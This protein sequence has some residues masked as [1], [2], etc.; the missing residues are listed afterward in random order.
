MKE[1]TKYVGLD[2]HKA[3][4]AVAIAEAGSSEVRYFGEIPNTPEDINKVMRKLSSSEAT[5]SVCYEAGPCGYEV[6]R[7]LSGR[8]IDC[9]VVAPSMIP[10]KPGDRVKT[11]RRDSQMLA[12]L[13]RAGEL[14]S[15]CVYPVLSKRHCGIS[16]VLGPT[17]CSC[18]PSLVS[19]L[20]D[21]VKKV[22]IS[23]L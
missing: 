10:R 21:L 5:L 9:M 6:Y 1:C 13:H 3:T 23:S 8:G 22:D 19:D 16:C 18:K 20:M 12:R 7:H 17:L 14:T 2:V 15:V 11:D 4:I